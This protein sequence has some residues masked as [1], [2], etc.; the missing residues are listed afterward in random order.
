MALLVKGAC[1]KGEGDGGQLRKVGGEGGYKEGR[2]GGEEGG[3]EGG[4]AKGL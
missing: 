3:R 4:G 1:P 2:D